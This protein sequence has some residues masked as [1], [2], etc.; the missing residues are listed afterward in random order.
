MK[1][2]ERKDG[3]WVVFIPRKLSRSG[4]REPRYFPSK[5]KAVKFVSEFKTETREHGRSGVS[6]KEREWIAY[7]RNELG[8]LDLLPEVINH[9]KRTGERLTPILTSEAV[10]SYSKAAETEYEN[11][12]TLNDVKER[13]QVFS[14]RFGG[15][16]LHEV[17]PDEIEHFLAAFSAGWNRWS[18][19]KRLRPFFKY[20]SRRRWIT[21]DPMAE[22][23][24]PKTPAATREVY[25]D[26]QFQNLLWAA[27]TKFPKLLPYVVLCGFCYMRTAE[28]VR[29]YAKEQILETGKNRGLRG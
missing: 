9:W 7:A 17:M 13:V 6:G 27:E 22:I 15:R 20:A 26:W 19:H 14:G 28:L 11:R 1:P 10:K 8:N 21:I 29:M 3:R 18:V 5:T 24:T 23:P 25:T 16:Q 2:I 4:R 12:R